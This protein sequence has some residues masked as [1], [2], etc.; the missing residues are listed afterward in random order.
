MGMPGD[1][2]DT[3]KW[4]KML[5]GLVAAMMALAVPAVAQEESGQAAA[6]Q[7]VRSLAFR[8][9]EIAVPQAE[10][11]FRLSPDFRY[12]EKADTR[13][14]LEQLWGNPPDDTVLGMIVPTR[15]TLLEDSSWAVVIT[16]SDEGYV[17][18]EDAAKI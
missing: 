16:Y 6:E 17:S 10:A 14:V 2:R 13:K 15:P 12:L 3:M 8:D 18:D 9:G 11:H 1:R 4:N 5:G 7:L